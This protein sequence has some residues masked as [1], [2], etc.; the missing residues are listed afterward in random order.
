VS[1][2]FIAA[3]YKSAYFAANASMRWS[4]SGIDVDSYGE[5]TGA[6]TLMDAERRQGH[7]TIV[8]ALLR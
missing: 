8:L 3:G 7:T 4:I 2:I 6:Q 5:K 1:R